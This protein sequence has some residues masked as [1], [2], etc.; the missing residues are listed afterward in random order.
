MAR[1]ELPVE[2]RQVLGKKVAQLR[3]AGVLPANIYGHGIESV[4]VQIASEEM[5]KTL[6]AAAANEVIDLKVEGERASRPAVIH[7]IQ[8]HPL[9]SGLLHA[10]FYQVSLREKMRADVPLVIVGRSEAVS[11]Y[12]GV[13]VTSIEAVHVEALPLDI[14]AHIEVDISSLAELESAVHVRDL[15]VPPNVTVLNEPDVVVVKVASPTIALELEEEAAAAAEEAAEAAAEEG[16]APAAAEEE[17]SAAEES[18]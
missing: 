17:T 13:L 15:P 2:L 14:P 6:K 7:H 9:T 4:A 18:A 5:E 10:D 1:R 12:N 8:R 3:R 16:E 11:T